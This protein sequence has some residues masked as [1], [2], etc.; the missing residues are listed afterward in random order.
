MAEALAT[1]QQRWAGHVRDPSTPAPAGVD[2]RRLAVYRRLCIDSL[3]SLLAGSLPRLPATPQ[4]RAR[5]RLLRAEPA[6]RILHRLGRDK[7]P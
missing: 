7:H 3:D 1:L 5:K 2:A 6:A 4:L